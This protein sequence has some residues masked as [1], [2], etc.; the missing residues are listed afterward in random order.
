MKLK[1]IFFGL[2][3]LVLAVDAV[4]GAT[5]ANSKF[6]E[7]V[8]LN[9]EALGAVQTTAKTWLDALCGWLPLI[10]FF[11]GS[12]GT[13]A[14]KYREAMQSQKGVAMVIFWGVVGAIGGTIVG[15]MLVYIVGLLTCGGSE[16]LSKSTTY[17]Q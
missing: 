3:L 5:G 1:N 15:F 16:A 9:Q 4:F 14:L 12:I 10:M 8:T 6:G 13:M 11:I 17:W 2:M 7:V